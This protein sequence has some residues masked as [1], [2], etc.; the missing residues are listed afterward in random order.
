MRMVFLTIGKTESFRF[1]FRDGYNF[2]SEC[3]SREGIRIPH[4]D[5]VMA[6]PDGRKFDRDLYLEELSRHESGSI[7]CKAFCKGAAMARTYVRE[8][9]RE[10]T[11]PSL[12]FD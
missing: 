11:Q 5:E 6:T 3:A 10:R 7:D 8:K 4:V 9:K 1:S 2:I 12:A